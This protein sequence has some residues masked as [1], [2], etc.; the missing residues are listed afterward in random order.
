MS[1]LLTS[2]GRQ[3]YL[4]AP[5]ATHPDNLQSLSEVAHSLAHINR[6]TGHANRAYSVAEHSLLCVDIAIHVFGADA[7][8]Q[9]AV[10]MHDAHESVVGDIASPV[11]E[12]LG[13]VW[14][15]FEQLHQDHFRSQYG[16]QSLY[17]QHGAMVKKCDLIALATER[18]DLMPFDRA[19]HDPWPVIDTPTRRVNPWSDVSLC[20]GYRVTTTAKRWAWL[21]E[22]TATALLDAAKHQLDHADPTPPT[23]PG[24]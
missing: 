1:W 24:H 23:T 16:L 6:Y 19:L 20:R 15:A 22:A 17:A 3:H 13:P 4:R 11:K 8:G 21:F 10:L 9:L 18:R 7:G 12:E 5:S 2:T 14:A